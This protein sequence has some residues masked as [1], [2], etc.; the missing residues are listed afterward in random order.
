MFAGRGADALN[1][2]LTS[3]LQQ[4]LDSAID[5]EALC[6]VPRK[7]CWVVNVDAVVGF[8]C[9]FFLFHVVLMFMVEIGLFPCSIPA[10]KVVTGEES[11]ETI[12]EVSDDPYETTDLKLNEPPLTVSLTKVGTHFIVDAT[13]EEES[14]MSAKVT[15]AVD[16][17]GKLCAMSKTGI[18]GISKKLLTSMMATASETGKKLIE[19][20]RSTIREGEKEERKNDR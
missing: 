6:I 20:I 5:K 10:V 4:L 8:I 2:K 13:G 14:C 7:Q 15:F 3:R 11:N 19:K 9:E 1:V 17:G 16:A 12:I 18:G